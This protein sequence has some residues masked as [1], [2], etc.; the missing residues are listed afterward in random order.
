MLDAAKF[1][2]KKSN[3]SA[4]IHPRGFDFMNGNSAT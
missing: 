2:N 1:I 3:K 4:V